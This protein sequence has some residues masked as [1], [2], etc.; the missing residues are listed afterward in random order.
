MDY[1]AEKN[2]RSDGI[3]AFLL[4]LSILHFSLPLPPFSPPASDNDQTTFPQGRIYQETS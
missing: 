1:Q 4:T 3:G 2:H